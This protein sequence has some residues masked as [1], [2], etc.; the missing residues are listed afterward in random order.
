MTPLLLVSII[1]AAGASVGLIHAIRDG[2]RK[3]RHYSASWPRQRVSRG[4]DSTRQFS[5][6]MSNR[7]RS[8]SVRSCF[9]V[10][11]VASAMLWRTCMSVF[12]NTGMRRKR[13]VWNA[14]RPLPCVIA[15]RIDSLDKRFK[16]SVGTGGVQPAAT[17]SG[18]PRGGAHV[19]PR[20]ALSALQ[21]HPQQPDDAY[22][23]TT[24]GGR[25]RFHFWDAGIR[26]I[27][28]RHECTRG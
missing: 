23:R 15:S 2:R 28:L 4:N 5:A 11:G 13:I 19:V 8:Q 7:R 6:A 14:C 22:R 25:T 12:Y 10:H 24:V 21:R 3:A 27:A 17:G 1:A 9:I 18:E 16:G 20:R 26:E